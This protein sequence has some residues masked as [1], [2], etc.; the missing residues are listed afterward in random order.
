MDRVEVAPRDYE[1]I[2]NE[3]HELED[4]IHHLEHKLHK[5]KDDHEAA[6]R[7]G[8]R[9]EDRAKSLEEHVDNY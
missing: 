7:H 6:K 8:K 5:Y 3:N 9:H 2:K 1:F 4:K